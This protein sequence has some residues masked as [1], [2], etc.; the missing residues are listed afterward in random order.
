MDEADES[1][2]LYVLEEEV[3]ITVAGDVDGDVNV[4]MFDIVRIAGVY[5][6]KIPG[7]R[8]SPNSNIDCGGDIDIFGIVIATGNYGEN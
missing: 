5:G 3:C 7:P 2:N 4:N 8:Y 1:D 6:V